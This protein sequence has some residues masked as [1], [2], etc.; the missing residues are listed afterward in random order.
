[1]RHGDELEVVPEG[2]RIYQK[3]VE[4]L[5]IVDGSRCWGRWVRGQRKDSSGELSHLSISPI[6]PAFWASVFHLEMRLD[7]HHGS[8]ERA[9]GLLSEL[10]VN[11]LF[12]DG[13]LS[14]YRQATFTAVC[15][16]Q[17]ARKQAVKILKADEFPDSPL[18][19]EADSVAYERL[20][21]R[22]F[23]EIGASLLV[24]LAALQARIRIRESEMFERWKGDR[25]QQRPFLHSRAV[26]TG[27]QPWY[28]PE[29][30][31]QAMAASISGGH[32]FVVGDPHSADE[33]RALADTFAELLEVLSTREHSRLDGPPL[34]TQ[35]ALEAGRYRGDVAAFT[36]HYLRTLWHR[37]WVEPVSLRG[38]LTLAYQRVWSE[39]TE[40]VFHY[41]AR[42]NLLAFQS[43]DDQDSFFDKC[44][45][46]PTSRRPA[47]GMASIHK[48]DRFIRL[49]VLKQAQD[50]RLITTRVQYKTPVSGENRVTSESV[51]RGLLHAVAGELARNDVDLLRVTSQ[52]FVHDTQTEKGS[53][54]IVGFLPEPS[55]GDPVTDAATL[56]ESMHRSLERF[57]L[58]LPPPRCNIEAA[59]SLYPRGERK[60]FLSIPQRAIRMRD[61]VAEVESAAR[62]HR[63]R[64]VQARTQAGEVTNEVVD[65]VEECDAMLQVYVTRQGVA[66][67]KVE[68]GSPSFDWL[69]AEYALA[70]GRRIPILRM[71]EEGLLDVA[72]HVSQLFDRDRPVET[73]SLNEPLSVSLR[74]VV[75]LFLHD[76]VRA[77]GESPDQS[78]GP[79][80]DRPVRIRH[81]RRR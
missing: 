64:V 44:G 2:I 26:E 75:E 42:N 61:I 80:R 79:I 71:Q 78:T 8:L 53:I 58:T 57:R 24:N 11:L 23:Q 50:E 52:S 3:T 22:Q 46:A 1:M 32:P 39:R 10:G 14:G 28:L 34:L 16:L 25:R 33:S 70:R 63:F 6:H 29:S 69:I 17:R 62:K 55:D 60:L 72:K 51:T 73:F 74:P 9:T 66:G 49:R 20:R 21:E 59:V 15:E 45:V 76:L 7:E 27:P 37:H 77:S 5:G 35:E 38:L 48:H 43:E 47:L 67:A 13:A 41:Q 65:R 18:F 19:S 56:D 12:S 81:R 4:P 54:K 30:V 31:V 40:I 68:R 36:E